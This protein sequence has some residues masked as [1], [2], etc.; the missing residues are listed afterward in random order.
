MKTQ[1]IILIL[2]FIGL[3]KICLGQSYFSRGMHKT[4]AWYVEVG[5]N[6]LLASVNFDK[7]FYEAELIKISWRVGAGY[8]P[9]NLFI[10]AEKDF[11][12]FLFGFNEMFGMRNKYFEVGINGGYTL[13]L[14]D[15]EGYI[16]GDLISIMGTIGFRR[17]S[18]DKGFVY[19][20][21]FTPMIY[22]KLLPS[23]GFSFGQS[24]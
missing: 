10:P 3:G 23:V 13:G 11:A 17:Q 4:N 1:R 20:F 19:R 7:I 2:V 5:G 15:I 24:F 21:G 12:T 16:D 6:G 8:A 9:L 14:P 18:H 22:P